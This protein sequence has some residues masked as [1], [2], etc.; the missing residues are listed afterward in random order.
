MVLLAS[1][2]G[3][4]SCALGP[5]RPVTYNA[6]VARRE[7]VAEKRQRAVGILD[8]LEA[9]MPD[10]RIELDYRTPLELLVAV[11][12][13]AQCTDK[14]VNLVTPALFARFPDARAYAAVEA[15][16]VEPFIRTCGLY[17]A[18]AKNIVATARTLVAEHGGQVPLVRDTLAQLPGVGLKTAGVVC[19]HLGG[20]AAFP[21]DTHVK[22]LAYRMGLTTH[23][24]PDKVEKDLQALLP[25]E[26]WTLGHQLLVWHGRRMCFARSPACAS[27]TVAARCPKKGVSATAKA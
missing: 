4:P 6:R 17:R 11:I 19:I 8:G 2:K 18:K 20:D 12:L 21:V 25:R 24:D 15:T 13:S 14:R 22:R 16:D 3:R 1:R 26:R 9:A 5:G 7:T 23:E 27:C 10:A